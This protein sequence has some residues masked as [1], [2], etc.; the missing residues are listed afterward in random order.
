VMGHHSRA[1]QFRLFKHKPDSISGPGLTAVQRAYEP[2]IGDLADLL[3]AFDRIGQQLDVALS[4]PDMID[5]VTPHEDQ[6]LVG[7]CDLAWRKEVVFASYSIE[8]LKPLLRAADRAIDESIAG[9]KNAGG[10]SFERPDCLGLLT[11]AWSRHAR[12]AMRTGRAT[13]RL[14]PDVSVGGI[15]SCSA[16]LR[17]LT[18]N[19]AAAGSIPALAIV[20]NSA[21]TTRRRLKCKLRAFA[22]PFPKWACATGSVAGHG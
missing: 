19:I 8:H 5:F 2:W 18:E 1:V 14:A 9:C 22:F 6:L 3:P 17:R 12:H 21:G 16:E 4:Q 13:Y 11:A 15:L 20:F 7:I 10:G